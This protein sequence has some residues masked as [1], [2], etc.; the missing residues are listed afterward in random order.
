MMEKNFLF[1]ND[2]IGRKEQFSN[3]FNNNDAVQKFRKEL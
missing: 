2:N 3:D 1:T